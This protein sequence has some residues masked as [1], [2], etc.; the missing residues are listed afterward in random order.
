MFG[1]GFCGRAFLSL[2]SSEKGKP[3]PGGTTVPWVLWDAPLFS[4]ASVSLTV[5]CKVGLVCIA[6][7]SFHDLEFGKSCLG[8]LAS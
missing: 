2:A 1:E 5:R 7:V 3:W 8:P 6:T 4:L